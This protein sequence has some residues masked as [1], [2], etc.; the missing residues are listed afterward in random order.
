[1]ACGRRGIAAL[2][3]RIGALLAL[4]ASAATAATI[5]D[6]HL[7]LTVTESGRFHQVT[8]NGTVIEPELI[9]QQQFGSGWAFENGS[10]PQV[11]GDGRSFTYTATAR[12]EDLVVDVTTTVVGPL[13]G[14]PTTTG[15]LEQVF[16]FTNA[17]PFP[18][19]LTTTS[20]MD[21]DLA[22]PG[23][24]FGETV[25]FHPATRSVFVTDGPLLMAA[26]ADEAGGVLGWEIGQAGLVSLSYAGLS[27][28]DGPHGPDSVHMAIGLDA[29]PLAPLASHVFRFRYLFS[30]GGLTQPPAGFSF[31]PVPEPGSAALLAFGLAIVAGLRRRR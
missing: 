26:I 11:S 24:T 13:A 21:P 29:G 22:G 27:N 6:G 5:T 10:F 19:G 9:V 14:A 7:S 23:G 30:T 1:M 15:V 18:I 25:D 20:F 16:E 17:S 12:D 3:T 31:A 8:L 4:S 28:N 2:P